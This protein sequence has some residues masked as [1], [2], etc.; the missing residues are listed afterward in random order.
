MEIK[1]EDITIAG[2]RESDDFQKLKSEC[3]AAASHDKPISF[4]ELPPAYYKYFSELYWLY[5]DMVHGKLTKEAAEKQDKLNYSEFVDNM[6]DAENYTSNI[7]M[8]NANIHA[9]STELAN[10]H[11]AESVEKAL[12]HALVIIANMLGDKELPERV[13]RYIAEKEKISEEG[14]HDIP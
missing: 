9:A 3:Y 14:S 5:N 4:K 13:V 1:V 12:S 10:L 2:Y 7:A 8:W 6:R 11:K